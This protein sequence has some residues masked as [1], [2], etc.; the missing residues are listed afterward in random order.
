LIR[1]SLRFDPFELILRRMTFQAEVA[2]AGPF[3]IEIV[4]S[5]IWGSPYGGIDEHGF[6]IAG[7]A[8]FYLSGQAFRGLWL[9]AH[10]EYEN[11]SATFANPGD[12]TLIGPA[13]RLS[14]GILGAL[15]GDSLV[16]PRT[17]GFILSGGIGVGVATAGKATLSAP[18]DTSP[19]IR[20]ATATLYDGFDRVRLLGS[21]GLGVAF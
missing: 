6:A 18:G 3:A 19:G 8:V 17:G 9:K 12:P 4:P 2:V 15:F 7:N 20:G 14:S 11:F 1:W 21:L 16:I 10:F 5:W 13:Q